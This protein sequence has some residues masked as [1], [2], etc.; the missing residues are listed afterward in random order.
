LP[1]RLTKAQ[2]KLLDDRTLNTAWPHY[3]EPLP[4]RGAS[5]WE[6]P[7]RMWKCRRKYR[8]FLFF[9]PVLLRDQVPRLRKAIVLMAWA[10]RRLDGQ[11]NSYARA[12][13][14]GILPGQHALR[15]TIIDEI[16]RDLTRALV[17]LEGCVPIGYLI[18][19]IH[20]L[21]HYVMYAKTHGILRWFWMMAFERYFG[22]VCYLYNVFEQ[23]LFFN[24]MC[25]SCCRY[26][27]TVEHVLFYRNRTSY[28]TSYLPP[29]YLLF[30]SYYL[31]LPPI[32][33]LIMNRRSYLPPIK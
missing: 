27:N 4:Y 7:S 19:S 15:R 31:L 20:H 3:I 26:N 2:R 30:T 29:I 17:L 1:W 13:K 23:E 16:G 25:F 12:L 32:Y 10:L 18:P 8:L 6:K 24:F 33:L 21:S 9:L 28:F 5:F 14:L 22:G 11:V